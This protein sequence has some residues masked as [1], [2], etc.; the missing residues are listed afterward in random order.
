M[1]VTVAAA[2]NKTNSK[3][4][5]EAFSEHTRTSFAARA[6]HLSMLL[7]LLALALITVSCGTAQAAGT[8]NETQE[9]KLSGSLNPGTV[10]QPYNAVLTVSGGNSPYSFSVQS[11]SLPPGI[12]LSPTT[13][14]LS[15]TPSKAGNFSFQIIATDKPLPDQGSQMFSLNITGSGSGGGDNI[16]ISISPTSAIVLS[17][18]TEQFTATVSGTYNTGVTWSASAGSV[19]SSGLFTAPTV[20]SPTTVFVT[21]TSKADSSKSASATVTVDPNNLQITTGSL[22]QGEQG[23]PYSDTFTATGGVTPYTWSVSAGA[24]PPG[25]TLNSNGNLVGTPTAT[26]TFNFTVT[27]DDSDND[28]AT[29]QFSLVVA[30]SSGYDGPAELPIAV[31]V[32]SMAD[33]PAPG[34]V[35][36]VNS[37]SNLQTA[38]NNA[39]CGNT[40]QLQAGATFTG[41]FQFPALN[42]DSDHW[43]IVRTSASDDS[44]PAEGQRMTPCYAGVGSLPGRPQYSCSNPQ[45]VL[46]K[47]VQSGAANGPVIFQSGANHYRLLGLEITR[48]TGTNAAPALLSVSPGGSASYIVLDRS[49]VHG[50]TADETQDGFAMGGT[51]NVA[52]V[53][54]YFSDFH[55]TSITGTCTDAHAVSGGIGN[56]Q[57]G[58]YYIYDNFLEASSEAIIFGGAAA[59]TTPTD[60]TIQFNHFFKPWQWMPGNSPFQGGVGGKP[61]IVK[62]HLELKNAVRV[63]AEDNLMEDVWGGFSQT[64]YA[65]LLTP[66]NQHSAK[67]DENVCPICEVTDVTVR[68]THIFHAASGMQ[69]ATAISGNGSGGAPAYMGTRWSIHDIVMDDISQKY[70]GEGHLFEIVNGWPKN[71]LNTVTINHVTGFPDPAG[72]LMVVGNVTSNPSMYGLVF[73]NNLVTTGKGPVWNSGHGSDSCAISDVPATSIAACFSTYTFAN[74]AFVSSPSHFPPSSWPTGNLFSAEPSDVQFVAYDNGNGG[75]Y[76]LE[77]GSPY[78]N[79]GTDGKDLGADIVGLNQALNGVE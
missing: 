56:Y 41:N 47:L 10:Q 77:S 74:N 40:I 33:T 55:C 60:I 73:T 52:V 49:W 1:F 5:S 18:Q 7:L 31:P 32:S 13:G 25:I 66:K 36:T 29:G 48:P 44:L 68:Y 35:I 14:T 71:P 38:L 45:N 53:D 61:F 16:Q 76:E 72:G 46:V 4:N 59:T 19:N 8:G 11:G 23:N 28:P 43:I 58:I 50:T 67:K 37:G 22:P 42:C 54:S 57:D 3:S 12:S 6:Q 39:Q 20:T 34:P 21:A 64:G 24:L 69:L 30:G 15:G 2:L 70:N 51:N 26:G 79:K 78:K 17:T 65:I 63:L 62:N 9:L 75:N 27:V